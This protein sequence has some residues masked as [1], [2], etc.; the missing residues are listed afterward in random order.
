MLS[1]IKPFLGK[2]QGNFSYEMLLFCWQQ[3]SKPFSWKT[4]QDVWRLLHFQTH[5]IRDSKSQHLQRYS[6]CGAAF[7][8]NHEKIAVLL[9]FDSYCRRIA[10]IVRINILVDRYS[11]KLIFTQIWLLA[12]INDLSCCSHSFYSITLLLDD[13]WL[14]CVFFLKNSRRIIWDEVE[15]ILKLR[16]PSSYN[17]ATSE[18]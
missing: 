18:Q 11:P 17:R 7:T 8:A 9:H 16:T 3:I 12:S 6:W 5:I 13:N 14:I 1:N 2:P 10:G 15:T 4:W